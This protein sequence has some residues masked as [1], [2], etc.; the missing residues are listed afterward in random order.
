MQFVIFHG[1][2]GSKEG[3]WFPDL[4]RKLVQ[5][6]Q[7]VIL[8][9]F[10]VDEFDQ[11]EKG[12]PT[13]QNLESWLATFEA[14]VLP[15]LN[16]KKKICFIGH[17]VGNLFIL[18]VLEKYQLKL[19]CAIFVSPV[20]DRLDLV[21]WQYD[22][23]NSTFYKTDFDFDALTILAPT[24]YVLYSDTD[25]Y[26]EPR[27]ARH[28]AKVMASSPIFIKK[29][30]HLNSE[31]NLNEFPLVFDLCVTRLDLSLYQRYALSRDRDS[32]A[33][34][35]LNSKQ[36]F[37][38]ISPEEGKDEGRFHFMN[39]SQT[40]FATFDSNSQDWD[41]EEQYFKDGRNAAQRGVDFSRVFVV[42]NPA[43][44]NRIVL[45]QQMKLDYQA[46]IKVYLI[47]DRQFQSI[48]AERD[49]GIWDHEYLCIIHRDN[50]GREQEI[51]LDSRPE[52]LLKANQWQTEI[53]KLAQRVK[54]ESQI[55]DWLEK[56]NRQ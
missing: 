14:E 48:G 25:P 27:R 29:A 46:G 41:P 31:V 32:V 5:M 7:E 10:P 44:L 19:D 18:H 42:V 36:K 30:G 13:N 9:Q 26:V 20:L 47:D 54:S 40:G 50:R 51:L 4:N 43:D 53:L 45:R 55:N 11:I 33:Q 17:S 35:I 22:Q 24:S 3:N 56:N 15:R 1:S 2:L 34:N 49:F 52:T 21:P 12:Q 39:L 8:P 16:R 6:G 37:L 28:F 23:I 38:I